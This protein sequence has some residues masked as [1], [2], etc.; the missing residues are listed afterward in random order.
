LYPLLLHPC[1]L[2]AWAT[3]RCASKDKGACTDKRA[4]NDKGAVIH[5]GARKDNGAC[6]DKGV[7]KADALPVGS[8][9]GGVIE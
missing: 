2:H 6:K 1:R 3:W 9:Q 5:T 7:R 8:L 4:G